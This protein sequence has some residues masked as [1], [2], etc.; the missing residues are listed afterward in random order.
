M[1]DEG[2][3]AVNGWLSKVTEQW[4]KHDKGTA[5]RSRG[6]AVTLRRAHRRMRLRKL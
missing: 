5:F 1:R 6:F 3:V 2:C 4:I